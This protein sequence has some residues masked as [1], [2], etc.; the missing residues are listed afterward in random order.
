MDSLKL[1]IALK[2]KYATEIQNVDWYSSDN[3]FPQS[4]AFRGKVAKWVYS[5]EWNAENLTE[6]AFILGKWNGM[7]VS[8]DNDADNVDDEFRG[9][10][11]EMNIRV[12]YIVYMTWS[13]PLII[14]II[15][16]CSNR[17]RLW[18]DA[19]NMYPMSNHKCSTKCVSTYAWMNKTSKCVYCNTHR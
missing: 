5:R 7:S 17:C 9:R 13:H 6:S 4:M 11:V 2:L 19:A 8:H 18:D 1:Y 14:N 16:F 10:E 12:Y 3:S 15:R